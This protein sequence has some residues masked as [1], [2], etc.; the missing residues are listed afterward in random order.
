MTENEYDDASGDWCHHDDYDKEE[1]DDHNYG[2]NEDEIKNSIHA[3]CNQPN[4]LSPLT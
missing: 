3:K 2:N 4:R 1:D